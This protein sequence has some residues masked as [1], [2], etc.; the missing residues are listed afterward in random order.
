VALSEEGIP[1]FALVPMPLLKGVI[2]IE[3]GDGLPV[4]GGVN[5][6]PLYPKLFMLL[7]LVPLFAR[8]VS[9]SPESFEALAPL[10]MREVPISQD[11]SA[12]ALSTLLR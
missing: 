9:R 10:F 2:G 5:A 8:C 11:R 3:R 1:V 7:L 6:P 4:R 12:K